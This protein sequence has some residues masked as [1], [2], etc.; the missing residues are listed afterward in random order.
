MN[1]DEQIFTLVIKC[2]LDLNH[3][4]KIKVIHR[5]VQ[6]FPPRWR[7]DANRA[8]NSDWKTKTMESAMKGVNEHN[9]KHVHRCYFR[10]R[11]PPSNAEYSILKICEFECVRVCFVG[12]VCRLIEFVT[13]Y[14][15]TGGV[16]RVA[17][18]PGGCWCFFFFNF[19][20]ST[21]EFSLFSS[22]KLDLVARGARRSWK[23][24]HS[25]LQLRTQRIGVFT[26][27]YANTNTNHYRK[28]VY[29]INRLKVL[30]SKPNI[31]VFLF[32]RFQTYDYEHIICFI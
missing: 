26:M 4:V 5:G 18:S 31:E 20:K 15:C 9:R 10:H 16:A 13:P 25:T 21:I 7:G 28:Y 8:L 22:E 1:H 29:H 27:E 3:R 14:A 17:R 12:F 11:P 19:P 6:P 30:N 24:V 23:S 2:S 32:K